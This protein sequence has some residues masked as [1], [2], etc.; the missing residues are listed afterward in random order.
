MD[1]RRVFRCAAL[2]FYVGIAAVVLGLGLSTQDASCVLYISFAEENV[3]KRPNLIYL[4]VKGVEDMAEMSKKIR[5][6]D[7]EKLSKVNPETLQLWKKYNIDMTLRELSVKSIN[8]YKN[9][10]ENWWIYILDNQDNKSI[11]ELCE[12]D[13]VEFFYFC[14][15]Q[16]NNS[17]RIKRRMSSI[18]AFYNFL[19]KKRIIKENPMAYIDRPKKDTDVI[20]QTFLKQE[21]V[22]AMKKALADN[23]ENAVGIAGKH[24]ALQWQ[25]YA[26]FSLSTMARIN[27]VHSVRWE[28]I[29]YENRTVSNVVEKEGYVVTLYFSKEV[30]GLLQGLYKFREDNKIDDSGYVFVSVINGKYDACSTGTLTDWC[31][32]IG[33]MIGVPTLHAHDFRHSGATLLKNKG[34]A[35]EDVSALL[36]H[37][38]TD[39]TRKFYIRADTKKITE[40]KDKFEI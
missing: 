11:I 30:C 19:M 21:Q 17:R 2:G 35:L 13:L 3:R 33:E 4:F 34:M 14:K 12:D 16:G 36:N 29:D 10:L 9:D 6:M 22:D 37:S 15:T 40:N 20:T 32:S 27:A 18:S 39:V 26:L 24:R 7:K 31:H 1:G 38:G 28:Q 5:L 8:G 23:V 25:V